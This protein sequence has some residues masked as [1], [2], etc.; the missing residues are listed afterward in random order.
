MCFQRKQITPTSQTILWWQWPTVT[1]KMLCISS[2]IMKTLSFPNDIHANL[3]AFDPLVPVIYIDKPSYFLA[4]ILQFCSTATLKIRSRLPNSNQLFLN[5]NPIFICIAIYRFQKIYTKLICSTI[6][7][8][9]NLTV[10][11]K[12]RS[13]SPILISYWYCPNNI[14]MWIW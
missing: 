13:R 10:T 1:L 6:I 7:S 8:I 2:N 5:K 12:I 4:Q 11:L 3:V 14:D 9:L